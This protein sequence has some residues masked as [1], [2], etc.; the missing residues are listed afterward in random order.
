MF[1]LILLLKIIS[2]LCLCFLSWR[3]QVCFPVSMSLCF[4]STRPDPLS[5]LNV[6]NE[7]CV[8]FTCSTQC[9]PLLCAGLPF[10]SPARRLTSAMR[11][12]KIGKIKSCSQKLCR[13]LVNFLACLS[14][15]LLSIRGVKLV[16]KQTH[17]YSSQI[18]HERNHRIRQNGRLGFF[19]I[20]KKW[21]IYL[22][23]VFL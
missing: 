7:H 1:L 16:K 5:D 6:A 22:G 9:C 11:A 10:T 12:Q 21:R 14:P 19:K 15:N 18:V 17:L 3:K 20:W 13:I 4:Q 23:A 2:M 8:N